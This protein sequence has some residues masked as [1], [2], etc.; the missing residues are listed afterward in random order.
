MKLWNGKSIIPYEK[1]LNYVSENN[2]HDNIIYDMHLTSALCTHKNVYPE[3]TWKAIFQLYA[4]LN[5]IK[6]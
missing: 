6:T 5:R 3:C 2:I 1:E 4:S